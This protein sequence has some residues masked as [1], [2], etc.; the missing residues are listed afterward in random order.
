MYLCMFIIVYVCAC[1]CVRVCACACTRLFVR[2][3]EIYVCFTKFKAAIFF[4]LQDLLFC[5]DFT[6][7]SARKSGPVRSPLYDNVFFI[8][9]R[10]RLFSQSLYSAFDT[11]QYN[12]LQ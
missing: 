4:S 1:V 3:C 2:V 10:I 8:F 7:S 12:L 9:V 11:V 5:P 6:V